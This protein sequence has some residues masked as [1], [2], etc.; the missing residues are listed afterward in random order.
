MRDALVLIRF[1]GLD[2]VSELQKVVATP[3]F[4]VAAAYKVAD[5]V[6]ARDDARA[7]S[8]SSTMQSWA[9]FRSW[10]ERAA[11]DGQLARAAELSSFWQEATGA[12]RRH[13][14]LQSRPPPAC[15][16]AVAPVAWHGT[17]RRTPVWPSRARWAIRAPT[18]STPDL[19]CE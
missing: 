4:D 8:A 14:G 2:I 10:H 17:L 16:G 13:A 19:R 6:A 3:R 12:H 15:G 11:G 5:S 18:L 1:A 7:R 9:G